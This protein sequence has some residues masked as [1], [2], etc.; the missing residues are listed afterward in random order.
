MLTA[1]LSKLDKKVVEFRMFQS[2]LGARKITNW[3]RHCVGF[4]EGIKC[5]NKTFTTASK[6]TTTSFKNLIKDI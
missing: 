5:S 1:N 6:L 3:V 2:E 4:V